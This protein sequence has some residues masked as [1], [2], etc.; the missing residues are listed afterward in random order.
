V[1]LGRTVVILGGTQG[2]G[3]ELAQSTLTTAA[4]SS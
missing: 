3:R 4:T 2:L 1:R